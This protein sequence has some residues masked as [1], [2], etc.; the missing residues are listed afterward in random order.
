MSQPI[1]DTAPEQP[2]SNPIRRSTA[3][4]WLIGGLLIL[5]AGGFVLGRHVL[6]FGI[7]M[8]DFAEQSVAQPIDPH[9]PISIRSIGLGTRLTSATL[10]DQ[11]GR[12]LAQLSDAGAFRPTVELAFGQTYTLTASAERL[13]LGQTTTR[14]ATF[15]TVNLP[16]IE[17]AL[18]QDLS[19]DGTVQLRFSEPVGHLRPAGDI[20]FSVTRDETGRGFTLTSAP[21]PFKQGLVYPIE[22]QW[23]TPTG[24]PLPPFKLDI[25]TAPPLTARVD[26]DGMNNLGL[27]MPV[28]IDFSEPLFAREKITERI[29]VQTREGHPIQGK[30]L[31]FG[32]QRVQFRPQPGWPAKSSIALDIEPEG[33]K[34]ARGGFL[35][36]AVHAHFNTGADKRIEVD[37][38]AQR[39]DV[40]ENGEVIKTM[41]AST[42]KSKTPTVTG[43]FYI[44]ARFPV[45]TMK[46]TGKKPGEQ[47]YYEVKD[48]PYAQYFYEGYAFHG[49]FWHNNFGHPA[50]HGCVNLA[51]RQKN[52]RKGVNEDAGWLYQWASIG[53]PVKVYRSS[54]HPGTVAAT[55]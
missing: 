26:T 11:T 28:Q 51:T 2:T 17:S 53:V 4:R 25:S 35:S 16:R 24:V 32:K 39:V 47:G 42:G 18:Q 7:Q 14:Q 30:W 52:T 36:Q 50:S 23:E 48:V 41:K 38:D 15:S 21:G 13:W 27:A 44:Y 5:L 46:S 31:W 37:L 8:P 54:Q 55:D 1:P 12:I 9:A 33:I 40:I 6:P 22:V 19:P 49:A 20:P 29:R 43:S 10:Q 34:S 45:K 3:G